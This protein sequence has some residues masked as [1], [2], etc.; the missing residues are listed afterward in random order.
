MRIN[1]DNSVKSLSVNDKNRPTQGESLSELVR[2]KKK[3]S[4]IHGWMES[5]VQP[6]HSAIDHSLKA[7][8]AFQPLVPEQPGTDKGYELAVDS[9]PT[10]PQRLP[11]QSQRPLHTALP[12]KPLQQQQVTAAAKIPSVTQ[13]AEIQSMK[14]ADKQPRSGAPRASVQ[15]LPSPPQGEYKAR[16][17]GEEGATVYAASSLPPSWLSEQLKKATHREMPPRTDPL[18]ETFS[19]EAGSDEGMKLT[20]QF[21]SW[22]AGRVE[23]SALTGQWLLQPSNEQVRER[24]GEALQMRDAQ[25][26]Q[27]S[28]V[29]DDE[30]G[31]HKPSQQHHDND[32]EES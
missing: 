17:P 3:K 24:L 18:K 4:R 15:N 23:A 10:A 28:W 21:R 8:I 25:A 9:H 26:S 32:E 31:Q 30:A 29:L 27:T 2:K 11:V 22:G 12:S 13:Q 5:Q 14:R 6:Q 19:V 16:R 1:P 7:A 20:Y